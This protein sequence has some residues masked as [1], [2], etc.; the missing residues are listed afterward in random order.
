VTNVIDTS[1]C[2]KNRLRSKEEKA[3][4]TILSGLAVVATFMALGLPAEAQQTQKIPRI[5]FFIAVSTAATAPFIE[6]FRQGLRDLGYVEGKNIVLEIR[7][8]EAKRNRVADL[9]AELVR[10]KVD[11][12][13]AG[14]G[15]AV[16]AVKKATT[17][18]P[19]VMRYD[20]DPVRRGVVASLARPRGNITG[21]A[22]ITT[23]LIGK[24][25]ELLTE[26]VA[27]VGLR[28]N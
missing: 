28:L 14:G 1:R 12:I 8:G 3:M 10:L 26:V 24:H 15:T 7:G 18:I 16:D 13:V 19:I 17:T 27:G 11:V 22:S 9:A 5:G 23:N 4:P 25:L 2:E 20:G 21:V 6:A